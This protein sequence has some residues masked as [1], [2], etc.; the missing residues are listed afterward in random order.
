MNGHTR[1]ALAEGYSGIRQMLHR[2]ILAKRLGLQC[3]FFKIH[4][5]RNDI[6]VLDLITCMVC[7][8]PLLNTVSYAHCACTKLDNETMLSV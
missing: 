6:Q 3:F 5:T 1:T 7:F 2:Y 4:F 8:N